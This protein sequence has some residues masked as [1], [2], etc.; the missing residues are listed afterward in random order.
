MRGKFF[1]GLTLWL[2]TLYR[3]SWKCYLD[4]V[5]NASKQYSRL[6]ITWTLNRRLVI[7]GWVIGSWEQITE[8]MEK[9]MLNHISVHGKKGSPHE[10]RV[11]PGWSLSQFLSCV[12]GQDT[13]PRCING[14][15]WSSFMLGV[16][17]WWTSIPS[18]G[19]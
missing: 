4:H 18:R 16:T 9:M 15:W 8:N 14:C 6:S 10:A 5:L 12:L 1:F 11:P 2:D 13:P 17:L 3:Q 7:Q 19:E